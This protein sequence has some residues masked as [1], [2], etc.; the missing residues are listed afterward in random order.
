[1]WQSRE[2]GRYTVTVIGTDEKD[3][4]EYTTIR[5]EEY[6]GDYLVDGRTRDIHF[7]NGDG[8]YLPG[9]LNEGEVRGWA[10]LDDGSWVDTCRKRK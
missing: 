7:R 10:S 2:V 1:M 6:D 5:I 9:F 3:G 4:I 8:Y